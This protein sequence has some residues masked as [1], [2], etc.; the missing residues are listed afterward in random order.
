MEKMDSDHE[1]KMAGMMEILDR[2][3]RNQEKLLNERVDVKS[4]KSVL[5]KEPSLSKLVQGQKWMNG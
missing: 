2:M 3:V 5:V 1:N 4:G